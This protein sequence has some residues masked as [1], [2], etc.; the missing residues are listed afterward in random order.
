MLLL[1][2]ATIL[3]Q[4]VIMDL[5]PNVVQEVGG[6]SAVC[7]NSTIMIEANCFSSC[8]WAT[9]LVVGA[10]VVALVFPLCLVKNI[11]ALR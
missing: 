8:W 1:F 11:S 4:I 7:A 5:V 6:C 10:L 9:R 2:G 3:I